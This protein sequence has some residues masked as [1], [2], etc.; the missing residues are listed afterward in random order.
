MISFQ[1]KCKNRYELLLVKHRLSFIS[2]Y[3]MPS[4]LVI[5]NYFYDFMKANEL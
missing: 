2:R 4:F 1:V 5:Q 3:A